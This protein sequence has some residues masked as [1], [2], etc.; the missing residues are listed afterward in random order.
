MELE[1]AV[2]LGIVVC[3]ISIISFKAFKSYNSVEHVK[4]ANNQQHEATKL[5]YQT[6]IKN[7]ENSNRNYIY[8]IRKM[9]DSYEIDYD[10]IDY[11]E[12]DDEEFRLSELAKAIYPKLPDSI[13]KLIDKEEFQNA[14]LKTVEK[15]PDI[16]NTFVDKFL[17]KTDSGNSG[18]TNK[19]QHNYL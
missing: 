17:N 4:A 5:I 1:V 11:R 3:F 8:K 16:I 6:E 13:S 7:L 15:K 19:L 9:R 12:E 10:D 14:I 2:I 18:S